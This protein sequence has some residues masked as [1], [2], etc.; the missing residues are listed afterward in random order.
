MP[1]ILLALAAAT[2]LLL[3]AWCFQSSAFLV[4]C[5]G[6]LAAVCLEGAWTFLFP[7]GLCLNIQIKKPRCDTMRHTGKD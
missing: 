1:S 6:Y 7:R 4:F 2:F 3:V 5:C